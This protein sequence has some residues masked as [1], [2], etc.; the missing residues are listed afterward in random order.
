[1]YKAG[2]CT[3]IGEKDKRCYSPIFSLLRLR[4]DFLTRF[5]S[6]DPTETE[7]KKQNSGTFIYCWLLRGY[8]MLLSI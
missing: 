5:L 2:A 6:V 8:F 1:M 3:G 7:K 4:H